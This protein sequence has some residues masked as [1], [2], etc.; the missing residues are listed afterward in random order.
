MKISDLNIEELVEIF[1]NVVR[2]ELERQKKINKAEAVK[3]IQ[4]SL[5]KRE[6]GGSGNRTPRGD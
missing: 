2:A 5:K 1:R 6:S 4:D 3:R